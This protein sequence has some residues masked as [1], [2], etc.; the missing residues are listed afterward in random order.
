[1][2]HYEKNSIYLLNFTEPPLFAPLFAMNVK[3]SLKKTQLSPTVCFWLVFDPH[4]LRHGF[5]LLQSCSCSSCALRGNPTAPNA[6]AASNRTAEEFLA[7]LAAEEDW[8][9][10]AVDSAWDQNGDPK[11]MTGT[12]GRFVWKWKENFFLFKLSKIMHIL[13][14]YW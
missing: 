6:S 11:E 9:A 4:F 10:A 12:F 14:I 1:M 7:L 13:I 5:Q 2:N 8:D 3:T